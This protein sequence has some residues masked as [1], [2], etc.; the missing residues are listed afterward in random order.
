MK[1]KKYP[2][3]STAVEAVTTFLAESLRYQLERESRAVLMVS[4]G[5]SPV[6]IFVELSKIPLDWSRVDVTLT[7]ERLVPADDDESNE[8]LVRQT[9][10]Q[11]EASSAEF[12]PLARENLGRILSS[13]PVSL[14]GF[15]EDGHF[16]SI[17]PDNPD[18]R[19]LTDLTQPP[20]IF[21]ITTSASPLPRRTVNLALLNRSCAAVLL[22]FGDAKMRVLESPRGLPVEHLLRQPIDVYWAP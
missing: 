4:G 10:I 13:S 21:D 5:R 15:G 20:E 7:D 14:I 12:V 17:F 19:K 8:K 3:Q 22:A 9:L 11:S 1:L 6:Q 2:T 16:A 18:L